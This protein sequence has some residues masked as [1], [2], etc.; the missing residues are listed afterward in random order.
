MAKRNLCLPLRLRR[1]D[2]SVTHRLCGH[3]IQQPESQ[4]E[5]TM[6]GVYIPRYEP[7]S[8][9]GAYYSNHA[10]QIIV[11]G[12]SLKFSGSSDSL[13]VIWE[14][15]GITVTQPGLYLIQFSAEYT[16]EEN[17]VAVTANGVEIQ[18]ASN[19]SLSAV[20]RL[21]PNTKLMIKN[22]GQTNVTVLCAHLTAVQI[23]EYFI[24]GFTYSGAEP[25]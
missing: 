8:A 4:E 15:D 10:P 9:G 3:S 1:I 19:N 13:N 17:T 23:M 22:V 5:P 21:V 16:E 18:G 12:Q 7:A 11:P 6:A 20:K 2:F 24:R 25:E 14:S